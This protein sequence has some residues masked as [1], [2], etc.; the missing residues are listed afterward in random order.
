MAYFDNAATTYPKPDIVYQQMDNVYRSI[1]GSAGRGEHSGS[2]AI[3]RLSGELREAIK[4][5]LHCPAK[6][7][8]FTPTGTLAMNMILQGVLQSGIK[9]VYITPF[10]HN[11]V[12]RILHH[13]EQKT[14]IIV[15]QLAVD[16]HNFLYDLQSIKASFE[17][18]KPELVVVSHASNVTGLL[19]PIEKIFA[20]AKDFGAYTVAD[21]SQTAGLVDVQ[22]GEIFDFAVFAGHKTLY[23]PTGI[24]GFVMKPELKLPP[25]LFGGT[26]YDSANQDMPDRLPEKFEMGTM[27]IS[28]MAGLHAALAWLQEQGIEHIREREK[29]N[30]Q[31]LLE[32]LRAYSFIHLIGISDKADYVGVVSCLIKGISSDSAGMIFNERGIAVRTG[33]QCAPL[34]HQFLGTYPAGTVR[35]SVSYFTSDEDFCELEDALDDIEDNL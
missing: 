13:Y 30:R 14:G 2:K 15:R 19:A 35:F 33:L 17:E 4:L 10:E 1:G 9:N 24:S 7:V 28:G 18:N 8:I 23:G 34:A 5:L 12:S 20:M 21:M 32:L 16:K 6:Q 27:N 31:R 25:I 29:C 3:G 11:A 22:V 26:G